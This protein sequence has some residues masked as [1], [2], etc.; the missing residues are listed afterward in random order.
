M[1]IARD[2][3]GVRRGMVTLL[4]SLSELMIFLALIAVGLIAIILV[5]AVVHLII[6]IV[7]AVVIWF[8][9]GSLTYAG[10]GFVGIAFLQLLLKRK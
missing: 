9:T 1:Q 6:P 2:W 10:I 4:P 3:T 8:M 5:K 7:A